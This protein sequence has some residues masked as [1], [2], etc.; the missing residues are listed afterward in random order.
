SISLCQN[1]ASSDFFVSLRR[2]GDFTKP[3][4]GLANLVVGV[5]GF[6]PATPT[7][8]TLCF[9]LLPLKIRQI[10]WCSFAFVPI[11]SRPF[12]RQSVAATCGRRSRLLR[13]LDGRDDDG[14]RLLPGFR[15]SS[16]DSQPF[17]KGRRRSASPR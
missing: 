1:C 10:S 9:I 11:R 5:A 14:R 6:E 4:V 8:R 16:R 2:L 7:S 15:R 17:A 12:C 3:L 13:R